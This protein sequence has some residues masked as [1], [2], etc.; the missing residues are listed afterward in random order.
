MAEIDVKGFS[1]ANNVKEEEN[2]FSEKGI[3]EPRVILNAD[4]DQSGRLNVRPGRTLFINMPGAHSLWG[5][6]SCM[7]FAA[8]GKLYRYSQG[9]AVN[10]GNISG[11]KYPLSYCEADGKVYISNPYWQG[12]FN[13]STNTVSSWGV[14]QPPGPML[15]A[16]SGNLPA[17]TYHV[18]MTSVS[19][20]EQ[21]GNGPISQITLTATGGIQVLNRPSGALVWATDKEEYIFYLVGEVSTIIDL[22]T[23]EPLT[24][25]MCTPPPM[26]EDLC[27]A[28]G[29]IWGSSG[30]DMYYSEPYKLGLF[31][32]TNKF[33]FDSEITLIA[34]VPTGLFVGMKDRTVFMDGT[35]PPEM[36]ERHAG[37]GSVRNS[38][39]Y[40][41]NLPDL[42]SVLGT[43]EK[44]FT[45]VPV[46]LTA[47]GIVAGN[48]DGHLFNLTKNRIKMG[49]PDR[50][51]SLYRN[52]N[53]VFQ[54]LTNFR[55]ASTGSGRGFSDPATTQAFID[56]MISLS[57]KNMGDASNRI[58]FSD[59][60]TLQ[61]F[62]G[63]VEI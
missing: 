46:W 7:L 36:Q 14:P 23:T 11:P 10:L 35:N 49:I 22:P 62:R 30:P 56:K 33:S 31:K 43:A 8:S 17:G 41:N 40:C 34:R 19:G 1:G 15:L 18:C 53:G 9:A 37:E 58:G 28:F 5:C 63:G 38:L 47:E 2:Y 45:D 13:P 51:A 21:S 27:Y 60:A 59:T 55:G 25:F 20:S 32:S 52:L 3:A 44:G 57:N 39:A 6:S 24:T 4:V 61:V 16:G 48:T 50:G 26:L 29:R 54:F 12:V 42:S